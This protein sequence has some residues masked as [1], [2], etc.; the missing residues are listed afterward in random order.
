MSEKNTFRDRFVKMGADVSPV[1][2]TAV[3]SC[4]ALLAALYRLDECTLEIAV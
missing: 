4:K 2:L 3:F 1:D